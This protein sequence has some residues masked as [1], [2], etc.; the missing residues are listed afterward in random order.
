MVQR[1]EALFN[2]LSPGHAGFPADTQTVYSS[3]KLTLPE[4]KALHRANARLTSLR[5][6]LWAGG[7][8]TNRTDADM[9]LLDCLPAQSPAGYKGTS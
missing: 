1:F 8:G 7:V 5:T 4:I 3:A 6:L 9:V 2:S